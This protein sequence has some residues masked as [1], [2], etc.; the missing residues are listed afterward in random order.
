[1]AT[2]VNSQIGK[3]S[4]YVNAV[5]RLSDMLFTYE[6]YLVTWSSLMARELTHSDLLGCGL[7]PSGT[8]VDW[9]SSSIG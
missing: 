6:R 3:N 4:E 5:V 9:G 2:Q 7:N 1:M 8:D